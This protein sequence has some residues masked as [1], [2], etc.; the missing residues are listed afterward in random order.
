[1]DLSPV[2]G[3]VVFVAKYRKILFYVGLLVE[4]QIYCK[5]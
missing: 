1:M 4:V 3:C 2:K 5:D